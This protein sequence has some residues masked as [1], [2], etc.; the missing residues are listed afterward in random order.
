MY[1]AGREYYSNDGNGSEN[2]YA[3][4]K[5]KDNLQGDYDI[6]VHWYEYRSDDD[7]Q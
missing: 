3:N 7:I 5:D 6:P 2:N 1:D 4:E